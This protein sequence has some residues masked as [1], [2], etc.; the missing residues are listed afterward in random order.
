MKTN[1]LLTVFVALSL[2]TF[3]CGKDKK[4]SKQASEPTTESAAPQPEAPAEA[5]KRQADPGNAAKSASGDKSAAEAKPAPAAKPAVVKAKRPSAP[6]RKVPGSLN[7]M[8]S[9]RKGPA[10]AKVTIMEISDFQ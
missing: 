8:D 2:L 1:H 3:G 7:I 4:K 10:I 6:A 5:E 9:P